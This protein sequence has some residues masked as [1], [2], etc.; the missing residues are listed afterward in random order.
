[1]SRARGVT[2]SVVATGLSHAFGQGAARST[3]LHQ[4]SVAFFPGEMTLVMGASGSGKSTL[5][6][7]LG[8]LL[9]PDAGEARING[10][11]LWSLSSDELERFRYQHCA[12]IFQ[13]FNLFPALTALDQVAL[14][15]RFGGESAARARS[16]AE[17]ALAEVGLESRLQLRPAQLSGGEKQR[18]AIARALVTKPEVLFA[19][20]PTSA[21][22]AQNGERVVALLRH[23]AHRY[24]T[25]VITVTH[26]PLLRQHAERVLQLRH[27]VLEQDEQLLV[28]ALPVAA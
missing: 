19:D 5:M 7:S 20:E 4:L 12:Y 23:I 16:R 28:P 8:G 11:A 18:V 10:T 6:A 17:A 26:D 2:A 15:L 14:P 24:G 25:T 13:G 27:G 1:M 22:D 21:L 3:V 9:K